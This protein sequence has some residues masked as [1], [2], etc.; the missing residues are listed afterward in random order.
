MTPGFEW[1]ITLPN[2]DLHNGKVSLP[3]RFFELTY[4][5]DL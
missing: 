2:I 5:F 4:Y 3:V 1:K